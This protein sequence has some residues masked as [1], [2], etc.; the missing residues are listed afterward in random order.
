MAEVHGNRTHP[1]A[2]HRCTGFEGQKSR[3]L[4]PLIFGLIS[5]KSTKQSP[6]G[7][8]YSSVCSVYFGPFQ[9]VLS[10][11]YHTKMPRAPVKSSATSSCRLFL[12]FSIMQSYPR[13]KMAA[14]TIAGLNEAHKTADERHDSRS[15]GLLRHPCISR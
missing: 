3:T 5:R 13:A 12:S 11:F 10:Q 14:R 8:P 7:F 4:K 2:R 9:S 15:R 1:P 6:F